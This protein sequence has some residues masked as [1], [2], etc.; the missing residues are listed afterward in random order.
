[1]SCSS[2]TRKLEHLKAEIAAV[3]AAL[4]R[5]SQRP[6]D[7]LVTP[8]LEQLETRWKVVCG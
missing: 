3:A 2:K 6:Y 1:M 4:E 5:H 7:H 8:T